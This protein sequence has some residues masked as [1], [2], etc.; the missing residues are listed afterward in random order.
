MP[1]EGLRRSRTRLCELALSNKGSDF[2]RKCNINEEIIGLPV[3][4]F[5]ERSKL[6]IYIYI[7]CG[8]Y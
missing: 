5:F 7:Y 8:N 4:L 3:V 1:S 2:V 6:C